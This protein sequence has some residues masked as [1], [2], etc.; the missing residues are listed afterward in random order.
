MND[1]SFTCLDFRRAKLAD[2][3]RLSIE[4]EEHL[5]GCPACQTFARRVNEGERRL[6]RALEVPVPDGLAERILLGVHNRNARGR[7]SYRLWALA[8][9]VVLTISVGYSHWFDLREHDYAEE[10]LLHVIQE[11]ETL[12]ASATLN[13]AALSTVLAKFGAHMREPIGVL[14]AVKVCPTPEGTGWH[15]VF[16]TPQGRATLLLFPHV[17]THGPTLLQASMDGMDAVAAPGGTGYY[18]VVA[19]SRQ[20]ASAVRAELLQKI[21]WNAPDA[22]TARLGPRRGWLPS[23]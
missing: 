4:A 17:K 3:R 5:I 10:A 9:T 19:D 14:R 18:A 16:D 20:A 2:P 21:E 11:P 15:I 1:Q 12:H 7:Q 8:A 6:A 23:V 13:D 22:S